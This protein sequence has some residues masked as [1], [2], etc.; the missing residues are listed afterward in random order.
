MLNTR[1]ARLCAKHCYVGH[2]LSLKIIVLSV[3]T[4]ERRIALRQLRYPLLPKSIYSAHLTTND[5]QRNT[6]I[7]AWHLQQSRTPFIILEQSACVT[8]PC[9]ISEELLD[10]PLR[11]VITIILF[12][13]YSFLYLSITYGSCNWN[14][15]IESS[16]T[17]LSN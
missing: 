1:R 17:F 16:S 14:H 9:G 4:N 2:K 15:I 5:T 3:S 13:P 11:L 12:S 10:T 7:G 8:I 6:C